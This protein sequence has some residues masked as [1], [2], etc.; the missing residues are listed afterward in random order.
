MLIR[1][2]NFSGLGSVYS[3]T[4]SLKSLIILT[5]WQLGGILRENSTICQPLPNI[6]NLSIQ[7]VLSDRLSPVSTIHQNY[8]SHQI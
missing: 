7:E 1:F 3:S 4:V 8:E 5:R 2:H 6:P